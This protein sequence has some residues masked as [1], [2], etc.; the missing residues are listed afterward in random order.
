MVVFDPHLIPFHQWPFQDP[1]K[2]EV[3][4]IYIHILYKAY[5]LRPKFQGRSPVNPL[6][7]KFAMG[8]LGSERPMLLLSWGPCV[9]QGYRSQQRH[10]MGCIDI[11]Y[12]LR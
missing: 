1:K 2:M 7:L 10:K 6:S 5:F 11:G 4:T 9:P 8:E 3:P 12:P